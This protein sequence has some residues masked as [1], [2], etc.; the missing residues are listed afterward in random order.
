[1]KTFITERKEKK[2]LKDAV[3]LGEHLIVI[4]GIRRIGKTSLLRVALKKKTDMPYV[5]IDIKG[6]YYE[7]GSISRYRFYNE[8]LSSFTRNLEFY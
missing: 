1:M 4:Y 3:D 5:L 6:I 8:I 2:E 7:Y